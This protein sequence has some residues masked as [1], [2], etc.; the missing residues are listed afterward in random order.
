MTHNHPHHSF[1]N[2]QT[3]NLNFNKTTT[4]RTKRTLFG[5]KKPFANSKKSVL[6]NTVDFSVFK[7]MGDHMQ[8][9]I[10]ALQ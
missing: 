2:T 9:E 8:A 6:S 3:S 4:P 5:F 7:Q 10:D 1:N